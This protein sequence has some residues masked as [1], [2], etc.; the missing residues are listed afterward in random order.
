MPRR[1]ELVAYF[2]H[3]KCATQWMRRVVADVCPAIGR[4][5]VIF[6]GVQDF[7]KDLGAAIADPGATFLCYMNADCALRA[8]PRAPAGLPHRPGPTRR[9]GLRVL[10]APPQPP[11]VR[12][13][14]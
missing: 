2:G 6:N 12:E 10:L 11:A 9:G 1:D 13:A 7:D 5:Q 8:T 3:H 4:E 14:G